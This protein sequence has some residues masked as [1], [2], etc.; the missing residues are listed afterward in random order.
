MRVLALMSALILAS[1]L[2]G[3]AAPPNQSEED[4]SIVFPTFVGVKGTAISTGGLFVMDGTILRALIAATHD[5]LPSSTQGKACWSGPEGHW[6]EIIRQGD[7]IFI[8]ISSD[9]FN[10]WREAHRHG[11][12]RPIH[13]GVTY[14]ISTDGRILRRSHSGDLDDPYRLTVS[15]AGDE[16]IPQDRDYSDMLGATQTGADIAIPLS[17]LDGGFPLPRIP[18]I[19]QPSNPDGGSQTDGGVQSDGGLPDGGLPVVFPKLFGVEGTAVGEQGRLYGMEGITLRALLAAIDD[20]R[21]ASLQG[22]PC[23][24]AP[25]EQ[26]YRIF[27]QGKLIFI[28]ITA[29]PSRCKPDSSMVAHGMKYAISPEGRIL[30]RISS[31]GPDDVPALQPSDA[32]VV[33]DGGPWQDGGLPSDGG[34]TPAPP[35]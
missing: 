31:G 17:W 23:G 15:D 19:P 24:S 27:D 29:N 28:E 5:F 10:C 1:C 16:R 13:Y 22:H 35:P 32:G 2:R 3:A 11:V 33:G 8:G 12:I 26:L 7:I 14:A 9:F 6:Y 30:R 18:A 25:E 34:V 21:L 20:F 4:K